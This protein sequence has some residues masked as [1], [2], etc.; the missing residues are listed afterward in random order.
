VP[1]FSIRAF[2][3]G[4]T[5]WA[6]HDGLAAFARDLSGRASHAVRVLEVTVAPAVRDARV[7]VEFVVDAPSGHAGWLGAERI[8][9]EAL[10]PRGFPELLVNGADSAHHHIGLAWT[11][12]RIWPGETTVTL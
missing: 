6:T 2:V 7:S 12:G 9:R 1:E 3:E 10:A 4:P 11:P 5:D 8:V